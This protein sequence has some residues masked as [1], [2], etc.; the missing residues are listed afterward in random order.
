MICLLNCID[1][2]NC[3][4]QSAL[5]RASPRDILD[6]QKQLATRKRGYW[7]SVTVNLEPHV[8]SRVQR[9]ADMRG[10]P[11][12]E[13]I[14]EAVRHRFAGDVRNYTS[15]SDAELISEIEEPFP[16]EVW[17]FYEALKRRRDADTISEKELLALIHLYEA[18]EMAHV[19]RLERMAELARRRC[20]PL[21]FIIAEY[22]V[23]HKLNGR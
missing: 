10:R 20:V 14:A 8:Q 4:A 23:R 22:G 9:E 7:M 12:E 5:S 13:L 6:V 2:D 11:V 15:L 3:R 1:A 16:Q 18:I 17:D 19:R 21:K